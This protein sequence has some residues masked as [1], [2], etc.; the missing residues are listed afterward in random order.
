MRVRL[1]FGEYQALDLRE[2]RGNA[3]RQTREAIG[4]VGSK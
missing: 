4:K 3:G 2:M 1:V